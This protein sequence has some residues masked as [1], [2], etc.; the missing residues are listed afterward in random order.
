MR[1]IILSIMVS[2]DGFIARADGNIDWFLTDAGF[3]EEMLTVLNGVDAMLFGRKSYELLA[4][5]WPTAGAPGSPDAP[6]GFTSRERAI[7]FAR[8][9]NTI[10]KIVFSS[11][12][13]QLS[14]GPGELVQHD[15]PGAI[16]RLKAAPGRDLVLFAGAGLAQTFMQLDQIDEYRLMVHPVMLGTGIALFEGASPERPLTLRSAQTFSSGVVLLRYDRAR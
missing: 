4:D 1:K 5:F 8:L 15:V 3:E 13:R 12:L 16:V 9:M 6:G 11:T 14:W 2:A 7:E 10:P